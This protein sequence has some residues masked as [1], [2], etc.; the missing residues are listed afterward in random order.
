VSIL[1]IVALA[2]WDRDWRWLKNTHPLPGIPV[3]LAI[4]LPWLIAITVKSHGGFFAESVGHDFAGK[5]AGGQE[6]H[7]AP[8]G[9]FLALLS[10]TFWPAIL[11]LLPALWDAVRRRT[12]PGMRFL[13]AWIVPS[14]LMFELVPT[15]LP[16]YVLPVYPALAILAAMWVARPADGWNRTDRVLSWIGLGQFV[17]GVLALA[18]AAVILPGLYGGALGV[19]LIVGVALFVLLGLAAIFAWRRKLALTSAFAAFVAVL[20]LYPTLTVF[21]VP[22]LDALWVSPRI[23]AAVAALSEPGDPP[24]TLAGYTE[25]S[26]MF[27]LGTKTQLAKARDAADAGAGQGGLALI[28]ERERPAF[29]ARL[30]ELEADAHE[31]GHVD[32]FNYSRGKPV[33]IRIYRIELQRYWAPPPPPE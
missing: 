33:H 9:Y 8:P 11:F 13:L 30:A 12:E 28:E 25:P 1:T 23:K 15:K 22:S 3:M 32:G 7:G 4:V 31:V 21:L 19:P 14:W 10:L 26:A 18:G 16:H 2:T 29:M 20:I 6:S 27:M 5:I 17:L 24:A